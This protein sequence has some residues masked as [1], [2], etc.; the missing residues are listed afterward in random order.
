MKINSKTIRQFTATL[1]LLTTRLLLAALF[2]L[3]S[4]LQ[5]AAQNVVLTG[6]IGGRV[7]DQSGAVVPGASVIVENLETGVKKSAETNHTGL[8]RFPVL[9]PGSYSIRASFKGFRDVQVLVRVLVGNHLR[10]SLYRSPSIHHR[11]QRD[12]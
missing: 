12:C 5:L 8:Y 3:A 11:V 9:M 6:A 2:V 10:C 7:T 4:M 1:S